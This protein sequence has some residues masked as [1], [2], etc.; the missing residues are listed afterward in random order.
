[1]SIIDF[2]TSPDWGTVPDWLAAIGTISA[3][4][5]ALRLAHRDAERLDE[6]RREAKEDRDEAAKERALFRE[7]QAAEAEERKR[8]L[9]ARVTLVV[10]PFHDGAEK[11]IKW[12]V[13]NA[14]DEPISMVSVVRRPLPRNGSQE[15]PDV[16]VC[17][18]WPSIEARGERTKVTQVHDA[19]KMREGEVQF[20]DGAGQRWQ[21]KEFGSLRMLS[22]DYPDTLG[23]VMIER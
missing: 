9:A 7:Q 10:E 6:E 15:K 19:F 20:L 18:T 23:M 13:H 3:V 11:F 16:Q 5:V 17:H 1:M 12:T 8:R 21:R 2:F 14:G 22:R 4:V